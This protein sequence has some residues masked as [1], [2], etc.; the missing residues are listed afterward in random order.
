MNGR[1][2]EEAFL[3]AGVTPDVKTLL[4]LQ[5]G[6]KLR[7]RGGGRIQLLT[8]VRGGKR[9]Q[10]RAE[11]HDPPACPLRHRG[12]QRVD[13]MSFALAQ[14]LQRLSQLRRREQRLSG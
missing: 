14:R 13:V 6:G 5:R 12:E 7:R 8:G 9:L 2:H 11:Q 3:T 4:A 1:G 10:S